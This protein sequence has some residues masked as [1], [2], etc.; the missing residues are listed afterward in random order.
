MLTLLL[1]AL[2][3]NLLP[4]FLA[5]S[6]LPKVSLTDLAPA[7]PFLLLLSSEGV[8]YFSAHPNLLWPL[9]ALNFVLTLY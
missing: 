3:S 6:S 4:L 7:N 2:F 8:I 9:Q 1:T 5:M